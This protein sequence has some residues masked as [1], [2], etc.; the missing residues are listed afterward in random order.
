MNFVN[1]I[2]RLYG[3]NNCIQTQKNDYKIEQLSI[4]INI[5][6]TKQ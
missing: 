2:F 4:Y 1:F 6:I 3:T 5:F